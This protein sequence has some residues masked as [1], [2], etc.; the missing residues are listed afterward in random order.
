M[1]S[2]ITKAMSGGLRALC[3]R[4][5]F[6]LSGSCAIPLCGWNLCLGASEA[7][8]AADPALGIGHTTAAGSAAGGA[9]GTGYT[10]VVGEST[11]SSGNSNPEVWN[12]TPKTT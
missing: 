3:P 11:L 6:N 1:L 4:Y 5:S 7:G 12:M 8:S 9:L 10:T 2:G